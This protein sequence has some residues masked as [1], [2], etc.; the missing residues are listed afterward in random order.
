M[1]IQIVTNAYS[2]ETVDPAERR[3]VRFSA[4]AQWTNDVI[5]RTYARLLPALVGALMIAALIF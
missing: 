4:E 3:R 5:Y 2:P 1:Q